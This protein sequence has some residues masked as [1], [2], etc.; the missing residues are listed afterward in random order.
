MQVTWILF[1]MLIPALPVWRGQSSDCKAPLLSDE[2]IKAIIAN[3]RSNRTDLPAPFPQYR[4]QI[5]RQGCHYIVIESSIPAYPDNDHIFWLNQHGVIV[6]ANTPKLKCSQKEL[7]KQ[8]LSDIVAN[9]RAKRSDLPQPFPE[10]R[11][12]IERERCLYYYMEFAIPEKRGNFHAFTIDMF[13]E[14]M[15]VNRAE[16]Y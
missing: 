8:E 14:L 6:D 11:V 4:T 13:G 15:F 5:R 9:A 10:Y 1:L 7:S 3:E 12:H 2:Q 16:P